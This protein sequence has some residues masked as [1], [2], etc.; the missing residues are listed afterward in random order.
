M[1]NLETL[2][3]GYANFAAGNIEAVVAIW[4]PDIIWAECTGFPFVTGDGIFVGAQAIVDGVFAHIPEYYDEFNIEITDF[5]DG[6]DKI[7]MVGYYKGT[8]K[9]TGRKFK[10]NA[11]HAWTFKNGKASRFFQAADSAEILK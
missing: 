1:N 4:Q 8:Y 7:V 5:I 9:P 2:K 6:G 11:M 10:A 3:Q